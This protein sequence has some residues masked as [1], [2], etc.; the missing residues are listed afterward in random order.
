MIIGGCPVAE[1]T[2][3]TGED[4]HGRPCAGPRAWLVLAAL[5]GVAEASIPAEAPS[6][7][8]ATSSAPAATLSLRPARGL[9]HSRAAP[10]R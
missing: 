4:E 3:G 8:A 2:A 5:A 9:S 10:A 6:E 7:H 1:V